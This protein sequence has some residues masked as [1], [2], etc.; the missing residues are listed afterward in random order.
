MMGIRIA[1]NRGIRHILINKTVN[2]I[3]KI[4]LRLVKTVQGFKVFAILL[5]QPVKD[6]FKVLVY[7]DR[8]VHSYPSLPS[9]QLIA[10]LKFIEFPSTSNTGALLKPLRIISSTS[11]EI[12]N[13]IPLSV[14]FC[15]RTLQRGQFVENN[16]TFIF[17]L[18]LLP[19]FGLRA[20]QAGA[21]SR[22]G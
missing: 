14:N 13:S 5:N 12:L 4:Q 16:V 21:D 18:F 6:S 1:V 2:K 19:V 9:T 7:F 20:R 15:A 10:S 22:S 17:G 8:Y 11:S 3:R